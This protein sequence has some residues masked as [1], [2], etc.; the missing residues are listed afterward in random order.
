MIITDYWLDIQNDPYKNSELINVRSTE[1]LNMY[2]EL[3]MWF[4]ST[5]ALEYNKSLQSSLLNE[6]RHHM[7]TRLM[8]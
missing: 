5:H 2:Q 7:S 4:M 8:K 3:K 6:E 1:K